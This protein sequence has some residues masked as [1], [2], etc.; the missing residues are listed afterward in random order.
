[1]PANG[2]NKL[3]SLSIWL[4]KWVTVVFPL[5]PV[6]PIQFIFFKLSHAIFISPI[7]TIPRSL[8]LIIVLWSKGIAGLT[9]I[10]SIC[11]RHVENS[12]NKNCLFKQTD[13][14]VKTESEDIVLEADRE[15]ADTSL[16][17]AEIQKIVNEEKRKQRLQLFTGGE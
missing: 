7:T 3:F 11:L 8:S 15:L 6:I 16:L 9:T 2:A 17:S 5:V 1:M 12:S 14:S 10:D 13:I 4:N